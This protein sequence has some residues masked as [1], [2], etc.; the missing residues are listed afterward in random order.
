[1]VSR[2]PEPHEGSQEGKTDAF[3]NWFYMDGGHQTRISWGPCVVN[4]PADGWSPRGPWGLFPGVLLAPR[5]HVDPRDPTGSLYIS[6][7][8]SGHRSGA[9]LLIWDDWL[10][11]LAQGKF[12]ALGQQQSTM[13]LWCGWVLVLPPR[14]QPWNHLWLIALKASEGDSALCYT[15]GPRVWPAH[16]AGSTLHVRH[17]WM[18]ES[19]S[20][21]GFGDHCLQYQWVFPTF[22]SYFSQWGDVM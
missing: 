4:G 20:S 17:T 13:T 8:G 22:F 19:I 12:R 14:C 9:K 3:L 21:K 18:T 7:T 6:F 15:A 11:R 2:W 10:Y 1:M 5:P 16:W